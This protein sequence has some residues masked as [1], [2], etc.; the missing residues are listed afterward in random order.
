MCLKL[1]SSM[2]IWLKLPKRPPVISDM[3]RSSTGARLHMVKAVCHSISSQ[4]FSLIIWEC[5]KLSQVAQKHGKRQSPLTSAKEIASLSQARS[6][7]ELDLTGIYVCKIT[8][9]SEQLATLLKQQVKHPDQTRWLHYRI[10]KS[11]TS[12]ACELQQLPHALRQYPWDAKGI[13]KILQNK[14]I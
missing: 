5:E 11:G 13:K 7:S 4:A 3:H 1:R 12:A 14:N 6:E 8:D 9:I 2:S 10:L